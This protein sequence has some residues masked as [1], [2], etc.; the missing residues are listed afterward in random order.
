MIYLDNSAT[1]FPDQLVITEVCRV[2]GTVLGNP[3]SRHRLGLE[4][5]K[6]LTDCRKRLAKVMSVSPDEIYFTSG[7]TESD[8]I[9]V[10]GG[11]NI[12]KGRR[13]VTTAVEHPAVMECMKRLE[14]QGF[15][16]IYLMPGSDGVVPLSAF[17]EAITPETCLVS[18]M[19]VNNE[20]GAVMPV[21]KIKPIMTRVAPRA[22][23]HVD[24]VQAFGHIPLSLSKWGVDMAS[25]SSH[26]VH[27]PRGVG[28]LYVRKGVTLKTPS[29]GGGQERGLRSGTENL[30][31]IAGF[32][33]AAELIGPDDSKKIAALKEYLKNELLQ[34][35]DTLHNGGENEAPH[36]LNISFGGIRSEI[37]LNA[38]NSRRIYVS[39][40][41][42]CASSSG[43]GSHVL[44]AMNSPMADNAIRFSL[45]RY[46]TMEEME[47]TAGA[48]RE[49][50]KE[51]RR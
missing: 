38:L 12:K 2:M 9:A 37:M 34:I 4:A 28:A 39:S 50:V 49:I 32:V 44:K 48:V 42:A 35:P 30:G 8:N 1:T 3:S 22:L 29:L 19:A 6:L 25:V 46:N 26:K 33:L 27:G 17:R 47:T 7:G 18:V 36:I 11:A 51:L 14:E 23:L 43:K 31:G 45:S 10:M 21:D 40:G 13:V 41:S 16:V 5:E 24:A 20:T 15:E